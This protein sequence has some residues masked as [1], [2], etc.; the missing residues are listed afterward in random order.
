MRHVQVLPHTLG[1]YLDL[2][3]SSANP[4]HSPPP[5]HSRDPSLHPE[6]LQSD[7]PFISSVT[8][9]AASIH[10]VAGS[11]GR[12]TASRDRSVTSIP[13]LSKYRNAWDSSTSSPENRK[14]ES[15]IYYTTA[16]GS[17]YAAPSP[18]R[19]SSSLSQYAGID[20]GSGAS[21][22]ASVH[23][24]THQKSEAYNPELLRPSAA[25]S[26][27]KQSNG[28]T[29]TRS[30][31]RG[32]P[33]KRGGKSIKDFTQDWINQYLSGE[34]RTER[35]NWLSDDSGSEA[36]S[37]FT[38][39]PNFADDP[40]DDWLGLEQD[41]RNEDL[42]RTPTVADF[43]GRR[44]A[45]GRQR[46]KEHLHKR[47][48]TLRQ[49]DF[50][51]FAYDK[52]PT[53]ATMTEIQDTQAPSQMEPNKTSS[54]IEKPL[55]PPPMELEKGVDLRTASDKMS[56]RTSSTPTPRPKKKMVW[57]GKACFISLPLDDK[58]GSEESGFRLLE[59]EDVEQRL[60]QWEEEGYDTRG[61]SICDSEDTSN[62]ELGGLSRP[63]YPDPA[64]AI[65]DWKTGNFGVSIP[66]KA[67]WDSYV[68]HLQ[69][70]KL[71]ALGVFLGDDELQ[72]SVSPASAAISQMGP[73]PG[74]V[75]SP[76][77]PT[78]SAASNPLS[79]PHAF[80]P[81]LNQ[82]ANASIG[83]GSMASPASPFNVQTPFMGV[84]QNLLHGYHMPFQPT[85]PAQGS[86]TPQSFFNAR[87]M[88]PSTIASTLPNMTSMLSPVSPLHDQS[89]F[90]PGLNEAPLQMKDLHDQMGLDAQDDGAEGQF[91]R[92][93]TPTNPDHFHASTVEIAH[94]TP[95]GH[96]RGHNLSETLQKGLDQVP[97]PEYHLEA[98]I[99]R[100]L[101]EG[102]HEPP[103]NLDGSD[104][105]QSRWA[106]A[107]NG[108]RNLQH[109]PQHVHQF[110]GG[111]LQEDT[112][113][114]GSDIDTN[115][116][117]SGTPHG[118]LAN[119]I[120]W[121]EPKPSAESYG[122]GHRSKL[123]TSTFNVEAKEF[124]PKASTSSNPYPFQGNS[125]PFS[126]AAE[127]PM[128]TFGTGFKPG[129]NSFNVSAPSFT[130]GGVKANTN[131]SDGQG[132]FKFSSASLNVAAPVFSPSTSVQSSAFGQSI[133]SRAKIF[134]DV[135]LA[136]A[137]KPSKKSKAIPIV[138]PDSGHDKRSNDEEDED[139]DFRAAPTDRSKRARRGDTA[140]DEEAQYSV[141]NHALSEST[142]AQPSHAPKPSFTPAEG[143]EN[144]SPDAGDV[145]PSEN[146]LTPTMDENVVERK[147]TPVS[148]A[149]TWTPFDTKDEK[150]AATTDTSTQDQ[151]HE[152]P[153]IASEKE[154]VPT[155]PIA[156]ETGAGDDKG[157][158]Q[159]SK[160]HTEGDSKNAF[161]SP[162]AKPF[163][164]KP[165]VPEFV[166]VPAE[167][168][169]PAPAEKPAGNDLM[170][171]RYAVPSPPQSP[172][173]AE[174]DTNVK[175]DASEPAISSQRVLDH[176]Y[177]D[178]SP[179]EDELNAIMEQLNDDSDVGIERITT[180]LPTNRLQESAIAPSK[181]KRHA[182]ADIRSD[183]P[184]PSPGRGP[185]SHALNVPKLD[186]E[187]QSAASATPTK[188]FFSGM[189]SPV[190]QL[191]N[192]ND[193]HISDWDDVLSSGEGEKLANR[194]RFF[195]RRINDLIGSVVEERLSPLE[196][197]LGAI[198]QSVA[199]VTSA[200][201][202]KWLWNS[203]S[204]EVEDSDADDEDEEYEENASYRTRSPLRQRDRKLD[205]LKTVILEALANREAE[206][207]TENPSVSELA[208]LRDSITEL[209]AMTAHKLSQ[210]PTADL[211][212]MIQDVVATQLL[213]QQSRPS[214]AD[215]IGADSLMLQIDG[216]KS[217]L[218][219]T[220]ER[221][222]QEYKLR[223]DAQDSL[224]ELQRLLKVAEEDAA[225]HSEA[226]ESAEARF[227]Q[228][229][230][231]KIPYFEQV[232]FRAD[233]LEQDHAK[234]KLTLAEISSKNISIEGTL[235]EHRFSSDNLKRENERL[236]AE[237]EENKEENKSLRGITDH[238]KMRIEDGLHIRQ[239]L[240]EKLDRVQDEMA[241]VTRDV[242]RDQVSWRKR[243]E[244]QIAK[245][246]E[247]QA[248]YNRESKLREKLEFDITGLE[249]Q[250]REAAKL[251]FVFGQSQQ[252]N[253]RLEELVANMRVEHHDLELKA[254]R[255]E[256]EFNEARDSSR[257]EIQ[258]TR[259]SMEADVEAANS[260]VNILRAEL[261]AQIL[262]LQSQL[263]NVR[264]DSDTARERYEMLLEEATEKKAS[265]LA[266]LSEAK[267][268][269]IEE[270]RRSHERGLNDLRERHARAMHNSSEDRQRAESHLMDRLAL[271]DDKVKHLSDRVIHLEEKLEIA[272]SAARAAAEAAQSAK[273][274]GS[275]PTHAASP[276]MSFN[277]GSTVPDKISP[278]A[279]R[280]SILVLQDQLQQRESRIE[281]LEQEV[282]SVDKDAPSKLKEKDT[283]INWLREL[284][285]V[286]TDDLQDI[287]NTVSQPSFDHNSVRD[288][289]IR[290]KANLQ[291]QQ[292]ERERAHSG[293]GFP[294]IPSLSELTASPRSFPL[295]AAAA[296]GN[297]RKARENGEQTPSKQSNASAFLS[298]LLTPPSSNVRQSPGA[299]G[300]STMGRRRPSEG[301]PLRN[302][303]T[304]PRPLS[305]RAGGKA[306]EPPTTPP[307]LRRSS[308]DHDAEPTDYG[309]GSLEEEEENESTADG[310]VSASPEETG[311]DGPFGPEIIS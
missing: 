29:L 175:E 96:S 211:R 68:Q 250:E 264:L 297:W 99:D 153:N 93:Q 269:A 125:L 197:T 210:D 137:S 171:S 206:Q 97:H 309:E 205:K 15:S 246:N 57:R 184:S 107:E 19:L 278:Q 225:Q 71:R 143:K 178:G 20:R 179:D 70:E 150:A 76:P 202:N 129:A 223:R 127:N 17:P 157:Q 219:I 151:T 271:S 216:L 45:T 254:A 280:E 173:P 304:T 261:E 255:F 166:P 52:D 43:V 122:G 247:L 44:G 9:P 80:S 110:Y 55:P 301:R 95:R 242:T 194:S 232:Q 28:S 262:R 279:L 112:T 73:F 38:A 190:R 16:W 6:S 176:D 39:Q 21:S 240:S 23:S 214:D 50:W 26:L 90:H 64:E 300:P 131:Q 217:M 148:E 51:G 252:E 204:P 88:G 302:I 212:E 53:P 183:P 181:E 34:P 78:A 7:V 163:E 111:T 11:P 123:S 134:G 273:A 72:P 275:T 277:Q 236:K 87:H 191:I 18:R 268:R 149:S 85:P 65:E 230:E 229:K 48:D 5:P 124:D 311:D 241:N 192:Q 306:R 161:L 249:Q 196:R 144:A 58:R 186:F 114:E 177:S 231:E 244:E 10:S 113:Q 199:N 203:T 32:L 30:P 283:E 4:A 251:K 293:Q 128:F 47:E 215:E 116:S 142:N 248:S 98:A 170:A 141:P 81:Q 221:A 89:M 258:R 156:Q 27:A 292:Q 136:E 234:L 94:P 298:G 108:D 165:A 189:H 103:H 256:R 299:S 162:T 224:A 237:L 74:L 239:N 69:E 270:Q 77:I 145:T 66:D 274:I 195:D 101:D 61:F 140:S 201:Q 226:A 3:V 182:P 285:G 259:T 67:E 288:A 266:D 117:L 139:E 267:E 207:D 75:A 187:A 82:S 33:G 310:L 295:A 104:L 284:L 290:L 213:K 307:L 220:D 281:E 164:F 109:L 243:E 79:V 296:W 54:P 42:L 138:R 100:Q 200:G 102:D 308:Y 133:G 169:K 209:Q 35:S 185:V 233:T 146:K 245:Y 188:G 2:A 1:A 168:P 63:L 208:Q 180:P 41:T 36:P 154:A 22:P 238:L 272:Q 126:P 132:E 130:P 60:K 227:L 14:A 84:E 25:A 228:F 218:R 59:P 119:H 121:H 235:D 253:A 198:Q 92:P 31:K 115:P 167:P 286:R 257:M 135:E 13:P 106:L 24:G 289:A 159:S 303:D 160:E 120:P 155:Q 263:D 291:M 294:S 222:E 193:Q 260:Q 83:L 174:P 105:L 158:D 276:S 62:I 172:T 305:A 12:Q 8:S 287:I 152:V 46:A 37:F 282:A 147:D 265:A 40:S 49:E 86:L 91:L 56:D 118:P